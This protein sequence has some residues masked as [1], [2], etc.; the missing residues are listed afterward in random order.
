[1]IPLFYQ[2]DFSLGHLPED[3]SRHAI[4]VLRLNEGAECDLT[5]GKGNYARA[6]LIKPDPRRCPFKVIQ[7]ETHPQRP[8]SIHLAIAPTKNMDRM[9][10]LVEKCI[11]IGVEK[12]SFLRCKTSERT[13]MNMERMEK[14][15]ISAMKQ[16]QQA[17]LPKLKA[18]TPLTAFVRECPEKMKFIATV[19]K[20]NPV[21]L[22]DVAPPQSEYVILIGPEGDF[23]VEELAMAASA[24]FQ[25]VGLGPNRLRTETAGLMAVTA[26][27]LINQ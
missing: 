2:P 18:I 27:N 16:S 8:F 13:S 3:E 5:D 26:L 25:A 24:G 7:T 17:W 22:K 10:W 1:M 20:K 6:Q 14:I 21:Q 9:E 23:T 19:D 15:A 11:E 4:K 12:I